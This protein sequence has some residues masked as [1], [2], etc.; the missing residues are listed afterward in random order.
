MIGL[1][2]ESNKN[3]NDKPLC[4]FSIKN[5][6]KQRTLKSIIFNNSKNLEK[7]DDIDWG[8]ITLPFASKILH[9]R[10]ASL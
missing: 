1:V 7:M 10:D 3:N 6:Q 9:S 2:E 8:I 5:I 4:A